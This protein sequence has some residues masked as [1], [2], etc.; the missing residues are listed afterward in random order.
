MLFLTPAIMNIILKN[1]NTEGKNSGLKIPGFGDSWKN[2]NIVGLELYIG[3]LHLSGI[4]RSFNDSA[5][6]Q[7]EQANSS[8]TVDYSQRDSKVYID[9]CIQEESY[10]LQKGL[11]L[12]LQ[13]LF[14]VIKK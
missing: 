12:V 4:Y 10:S 3:F 2:F 5:E 7:K 6:S 9:I 1:S 8:S 11:C 14:I 13:A